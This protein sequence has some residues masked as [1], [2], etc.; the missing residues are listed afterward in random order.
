MFT[1]AGATDYAAPIAPGLTAPYHLH[2][3]SALLDMAQRVPMG[4]ATRPAT[5]TCGPD[6]LPHVALRRRVTTPSPA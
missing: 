6:V 4:Q 5:A 2:L 1:A 3:F